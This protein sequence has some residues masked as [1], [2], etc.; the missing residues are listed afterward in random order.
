[1]CGIAGCIV[2]KKIDIITI[3]N[4]KK[5]MYNRGPDNQSSISFEFGKKYLYLFHSRLSIIDV[6]ERS[7]QPFSIG[8][9]HI[10]FNGEIYNYKELKDNYLEEFNFNTES[11]TEVLLYLYIKFGDNFEHLL[12]GMWSFAIFNDT[13]KILY[14]SKDR[15]GE[16]PLNYIKRKDSFI[17][18]SEIKYLKE[19]SSKILEVNTDTIN[20]YLVYGYKSIYK[21][22]N[23]YYNEV[24]R[25]NP[26][27]NIKI[28][29]S[30]NLKKSKYW[31]FKITENKN[32]LKDNIKYSQELL[33]N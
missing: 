11:D 1:M 21:S 33:K 24:S 25:L 18:G 5:I 2:D 31:S 20:R 9:F 13:K 6:S 14:I 3:N 17:F 29:P 12:E 22:N 27:T 19:L 10:I 4:M 32:S 30:L 23:T 7:N 26:S 16:K 28:N 15:F 8:K